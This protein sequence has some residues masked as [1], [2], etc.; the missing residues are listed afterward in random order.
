MSILSRTVTG[1]AN[2][3]LRDLALAVEYIGLGLREQ[4][5]EDT[6][7]PREMTHGIGE[8]L[9]DAA[10]AMLDIL[11]EPEQASEPEGSDSFR[12]HG[13]DIEE[14]SRILTFAAFHTLHGG[15][16]LDHWSGTR[17]GLGVLLRAASVTVADAERAVNAPASAP[18]ARHAAE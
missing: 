11:D 12:W 4:V 9:M 16:T 5:G 6:T 18:E 8:T 14:A 10:N 2:A 15:D 1:D 17:R 7:M 3:R 13:R